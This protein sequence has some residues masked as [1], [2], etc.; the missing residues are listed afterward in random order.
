VANTIAAGYKS[1]A[2]VKELRK[3]AAVYCNI[4]DPNKATIY[5]FCM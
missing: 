1:Q 4:P 5:N 3:A 2:M